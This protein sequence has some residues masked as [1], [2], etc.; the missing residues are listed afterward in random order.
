MAELDNPAG[1]RAQLFPNRDLRSREERGTN[2]VE[3][4]HQEAPPAMRVPSRTVLTITDIATSPHPA[5]NF[6]LGRFS[7]GGV[8]Q[9]EHH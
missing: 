2:A 9:M 6:P 3:E 5:F 7:G 1:K 8:D 4:L